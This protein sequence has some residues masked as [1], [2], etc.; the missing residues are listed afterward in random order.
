MESRTFKVTSDLWATQGQRLA[1]FLIDLLMRYVL[2][3]VLGFIIALTANFLGNQGLLLWLENIDTLTDYLIGIAMAL[4]YYAAFEVFL[5]RTIA[6]YITKT[7]V[8]TADGSKPDA[9][10][11][12][13]RT[14]CRLIPF[15]QLSFV[16]SAR[17]WHDSISDTYVVQKELFDEKKRLFS[18]FEEIGQAEV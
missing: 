10:T 9:G 17:G 2:I 7:I 1:N 6:K 8:V 3:F 13:K 12:I 14:F 11:I 5:S 16:G 4:V 15:N 18:S